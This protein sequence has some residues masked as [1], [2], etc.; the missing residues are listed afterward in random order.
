MHSTRLSRNLTMPGSIMALVL[1]PL[2]FGK[3]PAN[4]DC[5]GALPIALNQAQT[6]D[7]TNATASPQPVSEAQCAGTLLRWGTANKD[8][9]FKWVAPSSINIIA[10][11][12]DPNSFDTSM[13]VYE[14]T[15]CGALVQVA[16]NGDATEAT[17]CQEYYSQVTNLFV[18]AG[19]TYY[20]RIGGY[21]PA[22]GISASG[23][24]SL[25]LFEGFRYE[26]VAPA[27]PNDCAPNAQVVTASGNVTVQGTTAG[28]ATASTDG[29]EHDGAIC[30]SGNNQ[31]FLDRWYRFTSGAAPGQ[32][33]AT[34][35]GPD[36]TCTNALDLKLALYDLGTSPATFN[37]NQLPSALVSCNDDGGPCAGQGFGSQ[38]QVFVQPSRTYL[39]RVGW[40]DPAQ[41]ASGVTQRLSI[42]LPEACA[43]GTF[44]VAEDE[45]CGQDANGG[46]STDPVS[47]PVQRVLIGDIIAGS[48]WSG[49]DATGTAIRDTDCFQFTVPADASVTATLRSS[50]PSTVFI[51]N[52]QCGTT[53][54]ILSTSTGFCPSAATT[55]LKPGNYH[56][57]VAPQFEPANPCGG[58]INEYRL[59]LTSTPA[60][61]PTPIGTT[62]ADPG[63]DS[64]QLS[65]AATTSGN[66]LQGCA[67]GCGINTGGN[68]ET[69]F[70]IPIQGAN[71]LDEIRCMQFGVAVLRSQAGA[72]G[73]CGYG[74]T[75]IQI[76][77][78]VQFYRD[79]D[80]GD[81]RCFQSTGGSSCDLQLIESYDVVVP[82]GVYMG[83]FN[84][85]HALC[86]SDE[87]NLVFVLATPNLFNGTVPGVPSGAGYRAGAGLALTNNPASASN[88]FL[89]YTLCTG[90]AQNVFV[91]VGA[92][93]YQWP[94]ILNGSGAGCTA[95]CP[96]DL[97]VD[98]VVNGDDL[99]ILLGLWGICTSS[100]CIGDLND[101]G[102]VNGDDLGSLLASWGRC[103]RSCQG[104]LNANGSVN[105][106][107]LGILLGLWG[108]LS[109][110]SP[111]DI[112]QDGFVD[113]ADL[114]ALLNLW[115]PCPN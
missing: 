98:G 75:D 26:C 58:Q 83:S 112:D 21:T 22:S 56:A 41:A 103:N 18:T 3:V 14:G 16:C 66:F 2:A 91:P 76:P 100:S 88:M 61:C 115:G 54:Q 4:D 70:A 95:N 30:Q 77:C 28:G 36:G 101:D 55:C 106:S 60:N 94:V 113:G 51:A 72:S 49:T 85:P 25:S 37:Y 40:R 64:R 59:S 109:S 48:L 82:S 35:S 67:T 111:A 86:V 52:A 15:D 12:C 99:G 105:G 17:E 90:T 23:V 20:F 89:Q 42:T 104:D 32:L 102:V 73:A 27:F 7:T 43:L 31:F 96:A 10:T 34:T 68:A 69:W 81:P 45:P 13:V 46:C 87:T 92:G 44:T 6:F 24:G 19:R 1:C 97:N 5:I 65:V 33:T 47:P 78:Q 108:E 50:T 80:G 53:Q 29:P 62:C 38:L 79:I 107:D 74:V 110:P 11:T 8:V 9:W 39:L 114:G 93:S 71:L 84:L 63:P 57:I